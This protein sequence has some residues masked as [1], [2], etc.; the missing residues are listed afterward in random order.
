MKRTAAQTAALAIALASG[1]AVQAQTTEPLKIALEPFNNET[2]VT[3][4][5]PVDG[6]VIQLA[7]CLDTSGSMEGLINQARTR[8]WSVVN[9]LDRAE[10]NGEKPRLEVA[11]I[12]YGSGYQSPEEGYMTC[13]QP[14]TSDL[15]KISEALFALQVSGSAEYCGQA[16]QH[17]THQLAWLPKN[18]ETLKVI[19]IAGNE[20]FTQGPEPYQSSVP[21]AVEYGI[22]VNTV[23][24]GNAK[25]GRDGMWAHAAKLGGGEF[26]NIDQ[27]R[28]FIEIHCPQDDRILEL[29]ASL[30]ETYLYYGSLG[31]ESRDRQQA[32]D[33]SNAAASGMAMQSRIQAKAGKS[34]DNRAWD[35]VDAS[36]DEEFEISEV[37]R[38][39]LP[40]TLQTATDEELQA[41]IVEFA[42]KRASLQTEITKLSTERVEWLVAERTRLG[43]TTE[44]ALDYALVAALSS[45]AEAVGFTFTEE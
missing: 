23:H 37:D 15:D 4:R 20:E 17:A 40:E 35:L 14:F 21:D 31:L 16:I 12:Q 3:E 43:E 2:V 41:K 10:L 39:L 22:T 13:V 18:D 44:D 24:C 33:S 34:Y 27:D 38:E 5:E 1:L 19:V 26:N 36:A 9:R 30:N 32:A 11:I 8:I 29:N 25:T 7:I 45:Q 42:A 28:D 6:P